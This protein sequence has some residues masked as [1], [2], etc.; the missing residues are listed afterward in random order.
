MLLFPCTAEA[1]KNSKTWGGGD[2][3][4]DHSSQSHANSVNYSGLSLFLT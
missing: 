2:S 1:N 4:G 3:L